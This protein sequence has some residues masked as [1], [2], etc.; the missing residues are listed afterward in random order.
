MDTK[1]LFIKDNTWVF[2]IRI[3]KEL[4]FY[5]E[6]NKEYLMSTKAHPDTKL[7]EIIF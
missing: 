3:P 7:E 2:R 1:Y 6:N 5:Y 4:Q